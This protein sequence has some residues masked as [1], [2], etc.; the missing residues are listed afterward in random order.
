M[1]LLQSLPDEWSL[2]IVQLVGLVVVLWPRHEIE[3]LRNLKYHV[4]TR[5]N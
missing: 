2:A 5:A 4:K 1:L 3:K